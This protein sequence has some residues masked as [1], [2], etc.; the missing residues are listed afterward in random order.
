MGIRRLALKLIALTLTAFW[1]SLAQ[2]QDS[3]PFRAM[4]GNWAGSGSISFSSGVKE[5]IR[6]RAHYDVDAGGTTV[7]L[8]LR[9]ASDSY[10]FELQGNVS[11]LAGQVTG[12]WS[13][14]TRGTAG[15]VSGGVSGDRIDVR[16]EG[17]T[18]SALLNLR[19]RGDR[20]S[21]SIKAAGREMSEATITLDRRS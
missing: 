12:D 9:C 5:R 3:A 18:F 2:A 4:A 8:Q 6:C 7:Q 19:T 21:I 10:R 11:Y 17:Q 1:V 16:V 13:E 20:Q 14:L 15:R